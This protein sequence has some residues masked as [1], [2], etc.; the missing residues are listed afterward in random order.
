MSSPAS[1]TCRAS[2]G[3]LVVLQVVMLAALFTQTPP[4]PPLTIPLF[5]LGPFLGASLA[6]AVAAVLLGEATTRAGQAASLLAAALAL[7]SFGP[8]KWF[9]PT[10]GEIWPAVTLAQVAIVVLVLVCL[11]AIR[12]GDPA[13]SVSQ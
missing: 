9:D 3:V 4:H 12:R 8:Q 13:G 7:L 10:F 1:R 11:G 6:V 2:L 5:G